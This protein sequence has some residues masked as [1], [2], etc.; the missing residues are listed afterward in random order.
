MIIVSL[1]IL[2]GAIHAPLNR[3]QKDL[4]K[5]SSLFFKIQYFFG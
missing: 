3:W 5:S 2:S 4:S 1:Q